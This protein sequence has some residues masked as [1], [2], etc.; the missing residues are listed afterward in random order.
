M[1]RL[2]CVA[3]LATAYKLTPKELVYAEMRRQVGEFPAANHSN[4]ATI[5]VV[6]RSLRGKPRIFSFFQTAF[7][8]ELVAPRPSRVSI[9]VLTEFTI[10]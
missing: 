8:L 6:L 10:N 9:K 3:A 5:Y 7:P 2:L 4:E 1:K